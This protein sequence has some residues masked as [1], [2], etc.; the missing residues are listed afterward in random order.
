[1]HKDVKVLIAEDEP[2]ALTG[3][4]EL[5][6]G[7]GYRTETARDGVEAVARA[8][9]VRPDL[10][11]MDVLMPRMNGV[12]AMRVMLEA[13]TAQRV[14]LMSGE[15]RSTGMTLDDLHRSGAA[16]FLEKPFDVTTLFSLLDQ[17]SEEANVGGGSG[18]NGQTG[19]TPKGAS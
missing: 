6:S 16:A 7:W 5:I 15:F 19:A 4:A 3:L 8:E 14:M 2:N 1:M 12:E 11:V 18:K 10:V 13:G 17:W 9:Q